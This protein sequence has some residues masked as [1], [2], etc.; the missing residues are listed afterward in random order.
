[1]TKAEK[2]WMDS[3]VNLGCIVCALQGHPGTP[4]VVHHILKNGRRQS[5]METIPLCPGHHQTGNGV[6]KISRHPYKS[7]FEAAYGT[8]QKLLDQTRRMVNA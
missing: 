1:M 8:E 3:I 4:A 7:R 2:A 6:D 5:H